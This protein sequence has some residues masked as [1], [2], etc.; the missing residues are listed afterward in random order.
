VGLRPHS[1]RAKS[2]TLVD[3]TPIVVRV[4]VV[5]EVFA[6]FPNPGPMIG[7]PRLTIVKAISVAS[8]MES[9]EGM[10]LHRA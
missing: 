8:V 4:R 9:R 6:E 5:R 3:L 10:N 1:D 7:Q 2:T